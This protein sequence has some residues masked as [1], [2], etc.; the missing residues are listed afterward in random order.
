MTGEIVLRKKVLQIVAGV[1][2]V[3]AVAACSEKIEGG[4]SCPL[5]CPQQAIELHDTTIDA[6][7]FDTTVLGLPPIGAETFLMLSSHGDTIDTR[8]IF[9]F[10]TIPQVYSNSTLGDG[11]PI[12]KLDSV[13]L[14]LPIIKPDSAHRPKG[15]ITIEAY[16]VDSMPPDSV[17]IP[18]DTVAS[19]IASLFRPGRLIGS[20][21]FAPESLLDTLHF[22]ISRDT[23]LDRILHG[24]RLRVGLRMVTRPNEGY[25]IQFG[26]TQVSLPATLHLVPSSD[27]GSQRLDVTPLSSTPKAQT[28]LAGPLADYSIVVKGVTSAPANLIAVGG[29]PARRALLRFN[30]PSHIIDSTTIVRASLLLTQTPNR[31]VSPRD[32]FYVY[33]SAVLAQGTITDVRTLLQFVGNLGQFGLDSIPLAPG[34]SGVKAF[35]MASLLRT[36]K[37]TT[38]DVSPRAIALR[39]FGEA[40]LPGEIDFFSIRAVNPALRPRLRI[41]YAPQTSFGLP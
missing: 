26:T 12:S 3:F 40:A 41:I 18:T 8:V 11:T 20:K 17:T 27:S 31:R 1:M 16:D 28:F 4:K 19:V 6:V 30:I 23:V 33:P 29:I 39:S 24:T 15:P 5:L 32:S 7:T 2:A 34:D 9:R 10:D 25:N 22:P 13:D 14:R 21:T 35:E 38:A 36:W 37:G